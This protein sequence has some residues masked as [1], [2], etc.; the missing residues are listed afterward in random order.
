MELVPAPSEIEEEATPIMIEKASAPQ[1]YPSL[2]RI[3]DDNL[4]NLVLEGSELAIVHLDISEEVRT[5]VV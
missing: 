4:D 3:I 5:S 2:A 1:V